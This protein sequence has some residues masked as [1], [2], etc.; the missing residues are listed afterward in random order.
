MSLIAFFPKKAYV[1]QRN[2]KDVIL[3]QITRLVLHFLI[4]L[5]E[6]VCEI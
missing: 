2:F 1:N 6:S 3:T 5:Y 4:V